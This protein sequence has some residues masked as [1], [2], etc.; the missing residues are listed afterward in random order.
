MKVMVTFSEREAISCLKW[1]KHLW[2]RD[3]E[4]ERDHGNNKLNSWI[5]KI[6]NSWQ[7][8]SPKV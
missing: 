6:K 8:I 4:Q 3:R 1:D 5:K 2:K 7:C